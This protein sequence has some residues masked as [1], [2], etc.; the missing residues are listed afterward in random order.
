MTPER[1]MTLFVY[2]IIFVVLHLVLF[3]VLDRI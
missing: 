2:L 1:A 3:A